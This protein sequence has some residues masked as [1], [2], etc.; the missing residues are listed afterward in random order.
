M[1]IIVDA[2]AAIMPQQ[3]LFRVLWLHTRFMG[4]TL[5]W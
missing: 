5:L 4:L 3:R 1:K 2:M